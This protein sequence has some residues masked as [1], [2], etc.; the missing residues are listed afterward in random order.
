M[1]YRIGNKKD[2]F[3]IL[4]LYKKLGNNN[5]SSITIEEVYKIWDSNIE[6]KNIKYFVAEENN[7]II[8]SLYIC[9]I[10]NLSHNVKSIGFIENVITDEKY[11]KKGIGKKLMGMAIEYAKE[12]NCYKV[13]LQSGIKREEAHKFYEKIGFNGGSKKAFEFRF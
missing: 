4:E 7:K 12:N 5:D 1:D 13:T 8:G 2:L 6:N 9:I 11:R 10:P 3:S